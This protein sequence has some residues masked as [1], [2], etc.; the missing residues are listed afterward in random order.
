LPE[1]A[2]TPVRTDLA[3][4][5]LSS[6]GRMSRL[7]F[8]ACALFLACLL[9]GFEYARA[10]GADPRLGWVAYPLLLFPTACIL[11]KRLHDLGRAGWWG[12][13]IVWALI[14]QWGT[15]HAW[16]APVEPV[17]YVAMMILIVAE[18]YLAF[19][20]GERGPNRFGF[21]PA[22]T[23]QRKAPSAT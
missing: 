5:F 6:T 8:L 4:L 22:K 18:A 12:F 7:A 9:G 3:E 21:N 20:P 15:V 17:G 23:R 13:L 10:H 19:M 14:V 1:P 2:L 11:S 16:P